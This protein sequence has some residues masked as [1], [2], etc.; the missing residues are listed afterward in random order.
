[1]FFVT[2]RVRSD[3]FDPNDVLN[4]DRGPENGFFVPRNLPMIPS[5]DLRAMGKKRFSENV[6]DVVNLLFDTQLDGWSVE[7]AIGR[8]PV[9][10]MNT[11]NRTVTAEMW[12]NPAWRFER[13]AR[14]IEK[15]IRQSD[16]ICMIPTDWLMTAARIG[17]L[18]GIFGALMEAGMASLDNP[19]DVVVPAGDFAAPMACW[20]GKKMGLPIQNILCCCNENTGVWNLIHKGELRT[21]TAKVDTDTPLCD[22]AVPDGLE[23]LV[24]ETLGFETTL[25]YLETVRRG[26]TFYL[27]PDEL[28]K[29]RDGLFAAVVSSRQ[30]RAAVI[31][32]YSSYGY[33]PD[34]YTAL[35][36]GGIGPYRSKSG[37]SRTALI[38]SEESPRHH[39][40]LLADILGTTTGE[41]KKVFD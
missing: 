8:Y 20:Y 24:F 32:L 30:M 36:Y 18:F 9:K 13:L 38:L 4:Q 35:C 7:F 1:M 21:D 37:E 40:G 34:P 6:A 5:M 15:A 25:D 19:M 3:T 14:G 31:S 11:G 41:L 12:H 29:L 22:H 23:R 26:S 10:L 33:L 16:Q 39:I 2:T 27:E 28:Q 17:V